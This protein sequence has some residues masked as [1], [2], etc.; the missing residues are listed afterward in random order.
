MT[1]EKL[2]AARQTIGQSIASSA[3]L[4]SRALKFRNVN[5]HKEGQNN[6]SALCE[7]RRGLGIFSRAWCLVQISG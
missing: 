6:R 4:K 5:S 2:H 7:L 3:P 1:G